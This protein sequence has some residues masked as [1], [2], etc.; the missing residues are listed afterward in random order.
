MK[1][2]K[3]IYPGS[4]D[5]VTFG[6]LD[7][8]ERA[9]NLFDELIVIVA[10][11]PSKKTLFTAAERSNF[12]KVALKNEPRVKVRTWQGLTVDLAEKEGASTLI[13]GIRA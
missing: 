12:L 6:H 13:R 3:A 8:I 9:L 4:F 11:N 7:L 10:S 5:P 2:R 1:K